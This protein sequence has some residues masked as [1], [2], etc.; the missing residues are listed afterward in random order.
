MFRLPVR[1]SIAFGLAAFLVTGPG[2]AEIPIDQDD[3]LQDVSNILPPWFA[4]F[5]DVEL[6]GD[7]AYT[8]GVGGLAI[9][10]PGLKPQAHQVLQFPVSENEIDVIIL[11]ETTFLS[12]LLSSI[13]EFLIGS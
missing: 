3:L 13:T 10:R 11:P 8:F 12:G 5:Q 2:G 6:V 1:F 4:E 7:L 9:F